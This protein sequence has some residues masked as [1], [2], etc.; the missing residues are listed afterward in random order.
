MGQIHGRYKPPL[1]EVEFEYVA[2]WRQSRNW[3]SWSATVAVDGQPLHY[4]GGVMFGNYDAAS[5]ALVQEA[6]VGAIE[7]R[8]QSKPGGSSLA[9]RDR[10]E[11]HST[12]V[13]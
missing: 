9:P 1:Q 6:L 12:A 7:A 2:T 5:E 4:P 10:A 13:M 8:F 3:L 11:K